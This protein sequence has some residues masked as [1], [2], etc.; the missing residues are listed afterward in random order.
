LNFI[1]AAIAAV[2]LTLVK[3]DALPVAG[4]G[5]APLALPINPGD[6]SMF[7]LGQTAPDRFAV[8]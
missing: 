1:L 7:D 3:K 4:A 8:S 6:R 5:S 2:L